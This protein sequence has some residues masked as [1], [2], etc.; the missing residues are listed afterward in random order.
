L[1][2]DDSLMKDADG[3]L[4]PKKKRGRQINDQKANSVADIAAVLGKIGTSEGEAIGLRSPKPQYLP[5]GKSEGEEGKS[6]REE[7]KSE[8]EENGSP[9]P[10]TEVLPL[11]EVKWINILDAELAETW[12]E[13]VVHDQLQWEKNNRD[14]EYWA[15]KGA[16]DAF[17]E[18]HGIP[19]LGVNSK[20]QQKYW[21]RLDEERRQW[22]LSQNRLHEMKPRK[23]VEANP[24]TVEKT[25]TNEMKGTVEKKRVASRL[26]P[27]QEE[28]QQ[29]Q[30]D[31]QHKQQE[32]WRKKDEERRQWYLTQDKLHEM[33][34]R[35]QVNANLITIGEKRASRSRQKEQKRQELRQ[36]QPELQKK[37]QEY[38]RKVDEERRQWYLSQ[39]RL[40]EMKP[41]KHVEARIKN[42]Q[43]SQ[44][45]QGLAKGEQ[46]ELKQKKHLDMILARTE[47]RRSR[48]A[49]RLARKQAAG[50]HLNVVLSPAGYHMHPKPP[51]DPALTALKVT[52]QREYW[53]LADKKREEWYRQN[54]KSFAEMK[55]RNMEAS[56]PLPT[57]QAKTPTP[58]ESTSYLVA[59]LKEAMMNEKKLVME[60]DKY[61]VKKLPKAQSDEKQKVYWASMGRERGWNGIRDRAH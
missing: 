2:W 10:K 13:N 26:Q 22:Y 19:S 5:V 29:R 48:A 17:K 8:G 37:Q 30:R 34:P 42:Q 41:R 31:L 11:V 49:Y 55:P 28:L 33:K 43:A 44:L 46:S 23:H 32:Y 20:K 38:W 52:K 6:E 21:S 50:T 57:I 3:K 24:V 54:G 59:K 27:T 14:P 53:A 4:I 9:I 51:E 39:N 47:R 60:V 61:L 40:H 36:T 16:L 18:Q 35:K 25:V 12:T 7:D 1:E 58:D 15:K 56:M 45:R